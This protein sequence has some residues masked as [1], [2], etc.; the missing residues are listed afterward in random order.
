M[1]D[2]VYQQAID[3]FGVD[4]QINQSIQEMAELIKE[5]TK[6]YQY[7]DKF[8]PDVLKISEEIADVEVMITQLKLIF[9]NQHIIDSYR[10]AKLERL[11]QRITDGQ[12][13]K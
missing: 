8:E 6:A 7:G 11:Q 1:D 9:K 3:H 4:K 2:T 13:K 12:G 5:L 10:A